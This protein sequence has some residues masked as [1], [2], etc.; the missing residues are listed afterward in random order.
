M[1]QKKEAPPATHTAESAD[2]PPGLDTPIISSNRPD[3]N[4]PP[5]DAQAGRS[6]DDA[7]PIGA[8]PIAPVR[9]ALI[10]D[11]H[12]GNG[13]PPVNV[14]SGAILTLADIYAQTEP[15]TWLVSELFCRGEFI[16]IFGDSASGKTFLTTDLLI[17][18]ATGEPWI[19]GLFTVPRP[20]LCIYAYGEGR[21]GMRVS[22]R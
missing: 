9:P 6:D 10:E 7:P 11:S 2:N 8:P 20:A 19:D 22:I 21:R 14:F 5:S 1:T 15:D 13:R 16:L 18:L 17:A 3:D 12:G 4:A